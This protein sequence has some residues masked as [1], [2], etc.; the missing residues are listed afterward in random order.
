M[1]DNAFFEV[2]QCSE[3]LRSSFTSAAEV[4]HEIAIV[5]IARLSEV[6]QPTSRRQPI[7]GAMG[8]S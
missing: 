7:R 6:P 8:A 5:R 3:E 4:N 2:R 1:I